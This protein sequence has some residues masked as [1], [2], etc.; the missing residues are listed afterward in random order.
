[1][2]ILILATYIFKNHKHREKEE[3]SFIVKLSQITWRNCLNFFYLKEEK[4]N[5]LQM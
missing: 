4:Y 5:F 2:T 1:M 3:K